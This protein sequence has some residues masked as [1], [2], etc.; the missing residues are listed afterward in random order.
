VNVPWYLKDPSGE[1]EKDP[2]PA[3]SAKPV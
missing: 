2:I 1:K 3:A